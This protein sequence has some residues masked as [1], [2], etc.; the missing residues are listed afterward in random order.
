MK[1]PFKTFI[2]S[3]YFLVVTIFICML[4]SYEF[5]HE[6]P[7]ERT[8]MVKYHSQ[9]ITVDQKLNSIENYLKQKSR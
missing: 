9:V 6:T 7:K 3:I 5:S 1:I 2:S 8:E 4:L